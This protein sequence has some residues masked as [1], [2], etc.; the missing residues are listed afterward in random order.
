MMSVLQKWFLI[1]I[2]FLGMVCL[3]I[4]DERKARNTRKQFLKDFPPVSRM[5]YFDDLVTEVRC[6]PEFWCGNSAL[7]AFENRYS[8]IVVNHKDITKLYHLNDILSV[9]CR[10]V[11]ESNSDTLVIKKA[12]KSYQ[13]L[14]AE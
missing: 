10:I 3:I 11:K 9:G 14:I 1:G 4:F 5:S 12:G 7:I 8:F 6:P 13:F 2:A